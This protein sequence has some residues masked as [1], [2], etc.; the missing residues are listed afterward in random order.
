MEHPAVN[1]VVVIGIP[2]PEDGDH[3]MAIIL[4]SEN[5]KNKITKEEIAN[6]LTH[7]APDR[8]KL[9]GGVKFVDFLPVTPTGKIMRREIKNMILE[10]KL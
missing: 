4:P 1:Q 2:H 9:R 7:R 3:P 8:M 6:F 5:Y 10:G